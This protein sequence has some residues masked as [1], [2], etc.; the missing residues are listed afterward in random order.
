MFNKLKKKLKRFLNTL[1]AQ[2]KATY[3][4]GGINCC[5]LKDATDPKRKQK[6]GNVLNN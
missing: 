3:G 2:N 4:E 5:E 6:K 1:A